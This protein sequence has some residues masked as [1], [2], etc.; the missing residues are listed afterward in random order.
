LTKKLA[1]MSDAE[2]LALSKRFA[3]APSNGTHQ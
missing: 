2:L 3:E 1:E